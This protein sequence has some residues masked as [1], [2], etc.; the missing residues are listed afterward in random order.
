MLANYI[1]GELDCF[2]TESDKNYW[3]GTEGQGLDGWFMV[4]NFAQK[5][6]SIKHLKERIEDDIADMRSAM[7]YY[8]MITGS[9]AH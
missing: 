3:R 4:G 7:G 6:I 2:K 8:F 1:M 9:D 5:D